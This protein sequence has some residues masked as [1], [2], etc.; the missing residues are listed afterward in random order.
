MIL[1]FLLVQGGKHFSPTTD[2]ARNAKAS[3]Y[4]FRDTSKTFVF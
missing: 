1:I 3:R 4:S 2:K